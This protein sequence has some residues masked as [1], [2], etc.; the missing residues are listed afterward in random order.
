[1]HTSDI[2]TSPCGSCALVR[3]TSALAKAEPHPALLLRLLSTSEQTSPPSCD[4]TSLLTL[5]GI[6]GDGRGFADMLMITTTVRMIDW[7]HSNTTSLGPGVSLDGK[8]V[9]R[10]RRL[11]TFVS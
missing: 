4:E 11:C 1:M 3:I 10:S 5:G 9:L 6:S 8:L 2:R 7:V